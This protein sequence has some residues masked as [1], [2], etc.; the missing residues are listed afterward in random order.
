M[1]PPWRQ[2]SAFAMA[3]NITFVIV[4]A[5]SKASTPS[6][7]NTSSRK[8]DSSHSSV[9]NTSKTQEGSTNETME[10]D[11]VPCGAQIINQPPIAMPTPRQEAQTS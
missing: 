7:S 2:C 10:A 3:S 5:I 8:M 9:N 4:S 11:E 6:T 1:V